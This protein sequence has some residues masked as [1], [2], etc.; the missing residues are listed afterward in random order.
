MKSTFV[1]FVVL[2]LCGCTVTSRPPDDALAKSF[3]IIDK[4]MAVMKASTQYQTDVTAA[5][6]QANE[7]MRDCSNAGP[8]QWKSK[9]CDARKKAS[10]QRFSELDKEF[11]D[12]QKMQGELDAMPKN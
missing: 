5:L 8:R 3:A 1:A 12:L 9:N 2:A 11:A 6:E 4:S 10:L 7:L